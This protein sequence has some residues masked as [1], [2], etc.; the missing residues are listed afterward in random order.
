MVKITIGAGVDMEY[1]HRLFAPF[2]RLHRSNQFEGTGIGFATLKGIVERDG[3]KLWLESAIKVGA[4]FFLRLVNRPSSAF[5]DRQL[6]S[7]F[8]GAR[9]WPNAPISGGPPSRL[10]FLTNGN[11]SPI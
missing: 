1:A 6:T 4:T 10:F 9:F 7:E 2:R 8:G 5:L 11:N 3:G